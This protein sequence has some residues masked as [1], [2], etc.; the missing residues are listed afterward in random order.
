MEAVIID[1]LPFPFFITASDNRILYRNEIFKKHIPFSGKCIQEVFDTWVELR[2]GQLVHA[3]LEGKDWIFIKS[4]F[5]DS[6]NIG[7]IGT[8]STELTS[9]IKELKEANKVNRELNAVIENMYDGIYITNKEG[10]TVKTNSAIERLTGIPKE[11]Y[12]GKKVDDL[13]KRGILKNSVTHQVLE[14]K[15]SVSLVQQNFKGREVLLTGS[16]VLDEN[17]EIE[18]IVTNIRD[19]SELNDLQAA[20]TKANQLNNSYKEEIERLKGK[21]FTK[22]GVV[23]RSEQLQKIYE[24][25]ERIAN[26]D[27]TVLILGETGTGKDVLARYIF[28]N[29]ERSRRGQMIKINCG[30]IPPDLLE[31]ELFG[32]EA[33]AFTGASGKG[34]AG[35]FELANDGVLF[36]DEVGELPLHLQ[37]KLLR[38]IQ[39]RE[40]QRIGGTVPKKVDVRIIAATNR[41]LKEMVADGK[42]REDLFYRLNV[43]PISIPPLSDRKADILPLVDYFLEVMNSKY[44]LKKQ[45]SSGLKEFFY[46]YG[47]PG[48]VRELSNLIERMCLVTEESILTVDHLP[49]DYRKTEMQAIPINELMTLKQAAE[50]AEEQLLK[51]ALKKYRTTYE[52]AEALDSSQPTIVRKLKKYNLNF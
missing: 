44:S 27:A 30:A 52:L 1:Q 12:I 40:V 5:P 48:N 37:V 31:S 7:Y 39:E 43:I 42:F 23:I 3:S 6:E 18:S 47:W 8:F 22:S 26:V 38:V 11:Y 32:Y 20:L 50:M 19:L 29:S 45:L 16:P 34:K 17:G 10:I 41:N 14:K 21:S 51:L 4:L 13:I 25:A 24:T 36:L 9:L 2:G 35:M 33:G 15:R 28:D 46:N 49:V